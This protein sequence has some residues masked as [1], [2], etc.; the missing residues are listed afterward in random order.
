MVQRRRSKTVWKRCEMQPNFPSTQ[1]ASR[2]QRRAFSETVD[3]EPIESKYPSYP[4]WDSF[5]P[6]EMNDEIEMVQDDEQISWNS[7]RSRVWDE[8]RGKFAER[9]NK[10]I[11]V[12]TKWKREHWI[13]GYGYW[14]CDDGGDGWENRDEEEDHGE[15]RDFL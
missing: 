4:S 15:Q 3:R 10:R 5:H 8:N 13:G 12:N 2:F 9:Q 11:F 1:S 7:E 14:R 6:L